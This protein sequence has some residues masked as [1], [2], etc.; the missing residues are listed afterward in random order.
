MIYLLDECFWNA[1]QYCWAI[2]LYNED[3]STKKGLSDIADKYL[4]YEWVQHHIYSCLAIS[5]VFSDYE[6]RQILKKINIT[7]SWFAKKTIY[8]L[9]LKHCKNEQF[10]KSI[11]YKVKNEEN[12]ALKREVLSFSLLWSE[13]GISNK[14]LL[15][16]LGIEK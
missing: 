12:L 13:Q 10:L 11:L 14:D 16:A 1:D 8:E 5:Q 3:D 15:V 2:G 6:L 7:S 4:H 9:L